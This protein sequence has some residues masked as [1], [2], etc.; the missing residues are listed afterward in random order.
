[1]KTIYVMRGLP[2]SGKSTRARNIVEK[3]GAVRVCR[4]DLREMFYGQEN[5]NIKAFKADKKLENIITSLTTLV[6][7]ESLSKGLHV[8]IDE[9]NLNKKSVDNWINIAKEF[10]NTKV[11][12]EDF[13]DTPID[14]CIKRDVN[15]NKSVGVEVIVN[16][17]MKYNLLGNKYNNYFFGNKY[18]PGDFNGKKVLICDLDGTLFNCNHRLHYIK[19]E[20]KI[21][22]GSTSTNVYQFKRGKKDWKKF[23]RSSVY[24]GIINETRDFIIKT[25]QETPDIKLIFLTGRPEAYLTISVDKLLEFG[26]IEF[27]TIIMRE[28]N[29]YRSSVEYKKSII[30]LYFSD[31]ELVIYIDDDI[32]VINALKKGNYK[33]FDIIHKPYV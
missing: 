19:P 24:D 21:P 2:G 3:T 9:C 22:Y 16:M 33:N 27:E 4:D 10:K 26:I 29:D 23:H 14:I 17:A 20:D 13:T 6:V 25:L 12:I 8:V 28:N 11:E 32:N 1:M 7:R 18:E 5:S 31:C 15:R 30:D